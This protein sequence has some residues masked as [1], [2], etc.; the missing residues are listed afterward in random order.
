MRDLIEFLTG[1]KT[2]EVLVPFAAATAIILAGALVVTT[3]VPL[4]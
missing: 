3:I 4:P 1:P 2:M